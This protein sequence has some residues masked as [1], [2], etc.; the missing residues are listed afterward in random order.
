ML[1]TNNRCKCQQ[2]LMCSAQLSYLRNCEKVPRFWFAWICIVRV[3]RCWDAVAEVRR[4]AVVGLSFTQPHH[5]K[6]TPFAPHKH[7]LYSH[8]FLI[9]IPLSTYKTNLNTGTKNRWN[10][11][12]TWKTN[13]KAKLVSCRAWVLWVGCSFPLLGYWAH[14][15]WPVQ[16]QTYGYLPSHSTSPPYLHCLVT[17][18]RGC[19]ERLPSMW[20]EQ[21]WCYGSW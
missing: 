3:V 5:C 12:E 6:H 13:G 7:A 18:V 14:V 1:Y 11:S 19:A 10:I 4:S 20:I 8:H 2:K 9:K 15:T 16:Y 21:G 17:M